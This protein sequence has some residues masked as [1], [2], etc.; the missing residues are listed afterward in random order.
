MSF[1]DVQMQPVWTRVLPKHIIQVPPEDA[2]QN[3]AEAF[4]VW[5]M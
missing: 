3:E 5:Q 2:Q 1:G 4:A